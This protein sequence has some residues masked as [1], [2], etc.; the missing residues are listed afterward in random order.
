MKGEFLRVLQIC[1][2]YDP[3]FLDCAR[4]CASLFAGTPYKVTTIY[5]TGKPSTEAESGSASEEV[6]FLGFESRQLRGLKLRAIK[7]VRQISSRADYAF[8]IAHRS[9]PTY[10]ALLA[11]KLK[12]ISVHHAFGDF[13]R[14]SRRLLINRFQQRLLLLGVSNAVRDDMRACLPA[15]RPQRIET[16][17]NHI[18]VVAVKNE[19]LSRGASRE[20]LCLPENAWIIGNVGRLHPDKDQATL[21]RGFALALPK[22]PAGSLLVILGKGRLESELKALAA[23]CGVSEHVRFLGQVPHAM[24]YFKAFDVFALTSDHEPFGMV[25]LEAMAA[26]IPVVCSNN[27]G[28]AEVVQGVGELFP[29]G[30]AEALAKALQQISG[31]D[32]TSLRMQQKLVEEFSDAAAK[33]RFW[34]L[35][36][37]K[38]FAQ[39]F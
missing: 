14:L 31:S 2:S 11:T 20:K 5:L 32:Q 33:V 25:L 15:W 37:I 1:H 29:F 6:I 39:N 9:K 28:G 26:E 30:N 24:R 7:A 22:L 23:S 35:P 18:D 38:T 17:Y 13:S 8:C 27:G 3:P 16:L 34:Q 19:Q 21:I 36:Q 12:V 10:V 4:Q